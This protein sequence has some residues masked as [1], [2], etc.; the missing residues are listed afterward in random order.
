METCCQTDVRDLCGET[1]GVKKRQN[2]LL[3]SNTI[4]NKNEK[5]MYFSEF[6]PYNQR[7]LT[8]EAHKLTT[9]SFSNELKKK[10]VRV[11]RLLSTI[12]NVKDY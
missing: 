6:R 5:P 1:V 3:Y 8:L 10:H 7:T 4:R 12:R 11:R 2:K 9:D